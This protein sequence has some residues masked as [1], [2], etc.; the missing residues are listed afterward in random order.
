MLW[1]AGIK[2]PWCKVLALIGSLYGLRISHPWL[3][4]L[5]HKT[6]P[7]MAT[8]CRVRA[9]FLWIFWN[10][11]LQPWRCAAVSAVALIHVSD[12]KYTFGFSHKGGSTNQE[13]RAMVSV[14]TKY[15]TLHHLTWPEPTVVTFN[16]KDFIIQSLFSS[17]DFFFFNLKAKRLR[18]KVV[19]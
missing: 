6:A 17:P 16:S 10:P 9:H 3:F 2:E 12:R 13:S 5:W 7:G 14:V 1:R 8:G 11:T 18:S 15:L 4:Y 19:V